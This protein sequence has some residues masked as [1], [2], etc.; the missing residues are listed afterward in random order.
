MSVKL[1]SK[2][3]LGNSLFAA[4]KLTK[5]VNPDKYY[6]PGYG[7]GLGAYSLFSM[8]DNS[9]F[10]KIVLIF[11]THM[12]SLCILTIRRKIFWFLV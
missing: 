9:G 3:T 8:S 6:Y 12:N 5:N 7:I 2:F 11:G 10:G 4:V 1:D